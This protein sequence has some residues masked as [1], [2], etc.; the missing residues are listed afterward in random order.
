MDVASHGFKAPAYWF[1]ASLLAF[2]PRSV[3]AQ[4]CRTSNEIETPIRT[5]VTSRGP[6]LF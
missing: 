3:S 2:L 5:A 1:V 6:A 4:S